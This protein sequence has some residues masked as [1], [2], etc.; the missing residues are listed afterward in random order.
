MRPPAR[1]LF[2]VVLASAQ[3]TGTSF[4]D[5]S[6]STRVLLVV[7]ALLVL[8]VVLIGV[9][10]W[11]WRSTR[12]EPD[13]LAPLQVL[14]TRSFA[15]ADEE[16]RRRALAAARPDH[17]GS[18]NPISTSPGELADF[19]ALAARSLPPIEELRAADDGSDEDGSDED[20]RGD[21]GAARD[22][23]DGSDQASSGASPS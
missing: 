8:G 4:D 17:D 3:S 2:S 22:E 16:A 14:G 11:L 13:A 18:E 9:T 23:R 5:S 1:S 10:W 21:S 19:A 12:P 7:S 6:A 20:E 15:K